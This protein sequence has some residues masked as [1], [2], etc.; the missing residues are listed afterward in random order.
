RLENFVYGGRYASDW[1]IGMPHWSEGWRMVAELERFDKPVSWLTLHTTDASAQFTRARL[2]LETGVSKMRDPRS[3]RVLGRIVDQTISNNR[4]RTQLY[5]LSTLGGR[6]GLWGFGPG[7]FHD[8]D[9]VLGRVSYVFP[10]MR[11]ME[12]DFHFEA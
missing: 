9:L 8:I 10:L 3:I 6:F 1:R 7:R 4:D 5:D 2:E 12:M 11:R